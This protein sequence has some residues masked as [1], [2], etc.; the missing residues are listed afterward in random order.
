MLR[1]LLTF[2][3]YRTRPLTIVGLLSVTA[4]LMFL[5]NGT[6]LPF[7]APTI[8]EHSGGLPVLDTRAS[9]TPEDAYQLFAALGPEGRR[10][11]LLLHLG[12]DTLFPIGYALLF[13]FISAW[14][15]V[16]LLPLNHPL[17]WLSM[18]PL[19][20]GV[21]DILENVFLVMA[22]LAY[23]DRVDWIVRIAHLLYKVKFGLLPVGVV[24]L[25]VIVVAWFIR[26]RPGSNVP[27]GS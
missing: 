3:Q 16:R 8:Q 15:L 2:I 7:S 21:A 14:F 1:P 13:A 19:I 6:E 9:F 5:M 17:Q 20:S 25:A 26:K 23:P 22:N 18:I 27:T 4:L 24:F 10:A 12:P 11:Y